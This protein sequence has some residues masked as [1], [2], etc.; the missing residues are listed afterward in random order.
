MPAPAKRQ[1]G[2]AGGD[3]AAAPAAAAAAPADPPAELRSLFIGGSSGSSFSFASVL[4]TGGEDGA[5]AGGGFS[6]GAA[7]GGI[8][9]A[10]DTSTAHAP[11]KKAPRASPA[12]QPAPAPDPAPLAPSAAPQPAGFASAHMSTASWAA[13]PEEAGFMRQQSEA[14][15]RQQWKEGRQGARLAYRKLHED[16]M[17]QRRKD[18]D[19]GRAKRGRDR[20]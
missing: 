3:A 15:L 19:S 12:R 16:T 14:E 11:A 18:V 4:P 6:F 1:R 9:D 7:F 2:A 20:V 8:A 17:R 13:A 10:A 5:A